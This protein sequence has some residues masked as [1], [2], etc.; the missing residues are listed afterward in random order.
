MISVDSVTGQSIVKLHEA[1]LDYESI[2]RK[3]WLDPHDVGNTVCVH[4]LRKSNKIVTK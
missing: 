3:L 1:G 2:A 4:N